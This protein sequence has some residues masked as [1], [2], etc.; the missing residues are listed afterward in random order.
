MVLIDRMDDLPYL[1]LPALLVWVVCIVNCDR[2]EH[3][4]QK[5]VGQQPRTEQDNSS[6]P[7]Q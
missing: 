4:K 2:R 1:H 7:L 5:T 3:A 6:Q